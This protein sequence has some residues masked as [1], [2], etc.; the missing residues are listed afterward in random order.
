MKLEK[1][2]INL[3]VK[4]L[5]ETN[6]IYEQIEA[7]LLQITHQLP[8]RIHSKVN[9]DRFKLKANQLNALKITLRKDKMFNF[10]SKLFIFIINFHN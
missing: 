7:D 2:T 3:G 9:N 5:C 6:G 4:K 8:F 10:I 1:I